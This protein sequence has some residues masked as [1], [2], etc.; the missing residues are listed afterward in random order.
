MAH[1]FIAINSIPLLFCG[2]IAYGLFYLGMGGVGDNLVSLLLLFGLY[3]LF[4]GATEGVEKAFVADLVPEERRGTAYGW[5]NLV[6][7][8]LLLPASMLFGLFYQSVS[9]GCAFLFSGGCSLLAATLLRLYVMPAWT[10]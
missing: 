1:F 6:A 2:Y 9:P 7:G 3:G 5:F 4:M 10:K 8:I